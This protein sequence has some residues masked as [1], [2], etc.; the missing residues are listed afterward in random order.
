MERVWWKE[1]VVYQIYPRSFNDSNGDGI[2]DIQG[3]IQKLDYLKSLGVD[4]IWLCPIFSSPNDDN[5]YDISDY[6]EVMTEFGSM[7]DFDLLMAEMKKRNLRLLMDLVV[8]HSSDEHAWFVE[9]RSSLDSPKR[10]YYIWKKGVNGGPPNNWQSF[11][12]GDSWRYDEQTDEYF[13]RLF[14]SKQPDL[15]WE[16]DDVRMEVYDVMKFWLDKGIDGFRMDVISLISKRGYEDT[17]FEELNET[18]QKVYANG[19]RVHEFLQEM[20]KEVLSKYDMMTVGEGPGIALENGLDYV[21]IGRKELHMVFHFDH[22]FIDHGPGGKFDFVPYDLVDFKKVFSKWDKELA[23]KGWNSIFL[24]NHDFPRIVS[25][26]GNDKNYWKDSAKAIGLL[27]HTLRGTTY[28]YQG[29][30]IGMTNVAFPSI[31][32]YRDIETHNVYSEAKAQNK[33]L[34]DLMKQIHIQ[35]R[36]NARTPIQWSSEV[37]GGFTEG[38]PWI[39]INP[40][41]REINVANQQEDPDSILNFYRQLIKLRKNNL[42][43][44]Y[45]DYQDIDLSHTSIFSFWRWEENSTYLVAINMSEQAS[46]VS[47]DDKFNLDNKVLLLSNVSKEP[48]FNNNLLELGPWEAVIFKV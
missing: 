14:T 3:I 17:P 24:G 10:D 44:V 22:M 5:G 38:Q 34:G 18:V 6:R 35:G 43:L 33:D 21:G 9:S 16:N 15:N 30:E 41:Y 8:N 4:I 19:P 45:G 2:G 7:A 31:D 48:V 32:D 36:D 29:D 20:N 42:T 40:N 37:N 39:K 46:S 25:R 26:F 27:L 1:G 47:I 28:I 11:F 12:G 23:G 13:L